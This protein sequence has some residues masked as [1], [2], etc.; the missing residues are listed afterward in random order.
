MLDNIVEGLAMA[1]VWG[2]W[3][4][5]LFPNNKP[6]IYLGTAAILFICAMLGGARYLRRRNAKP[7]HVSV[8]NELGN[9]MYAVNQRI[10]LL[11]NIIWW[12][13]SPG[14]L[15]ILT[16]QLA[17]GFEQKKALVEWMLK[18]EAL[19]LASCVLLFVGV[20][21]LNQRAIRKYL[22]PLKQQLE[23][24]LQDLKDTETT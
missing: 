7:A 19:Y 12:Y 2:G 22:L 15:A 10:W 5:N 9:Q 6:L 13:L 4:P 18:T 14:A 1:C 21:W 16:V 8:F 17:V 20:Y 24:V 3:F 23:K 11:R